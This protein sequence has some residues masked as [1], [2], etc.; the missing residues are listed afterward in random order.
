MTSISGLVKEVFG[1]RFCPIIFFFSVWRTIRP[2]LNKT[3]F[4]YYL[5][6]E[7]SFTKNWDSFLYVFNY[8]WTLQNLF[9]SH[10]TLCCGSFKSPRRAQCNVRK[11]TCMQSLFFFTNLNFSLMYF[12][13]NK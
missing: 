5:N 3:P 1:S 7:K 9:T 4:F 10:Q 11:S 12:T 6:K 2:S 8:F 13:R